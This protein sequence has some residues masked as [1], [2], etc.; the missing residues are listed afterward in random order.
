MNEGANCFAPEIIRAGFGT[1]LPAGRCCCAGH[2]VRERRG[3]VGQGTEKP[4]ESHQ[5]RCIVFDEGV[6][7]PR[8][9]RFYI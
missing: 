1:C 6:I 9:L 4:R 5:N 7:P 8:D 3:G 2:V